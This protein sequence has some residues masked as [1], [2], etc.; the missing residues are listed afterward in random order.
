M[1][2]FYS[3]FF[4][5]VVF[6][7]S[8]P[9]SYSRFRQLLPCAKLSF[10]KDNLTILVWDEKW[11]L[12]C[13][14]AKRSDGSERL[15]ICAYMLCSVWFAS[16]MLLRGAK[17]KILAHVFEK[18]AMDNVELSWFGFFYWTRLWKIGCQ[19][20][21]EK[22]IRIFSILNNTFKLFQNCLHFPI[23]LV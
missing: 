4:F 2:V 15:H 11:D 20:L 1:D 7:C 18:L 5:V 8:I 16:S 12:R 3:N 10:R 23:I 22:N 21:G 17:I 14:V 6:L 19:N 13:V 9:V